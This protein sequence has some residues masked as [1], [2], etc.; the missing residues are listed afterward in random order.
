LRQIVRDTSAY[1]L[2]G[3][4][5]TLNQPDGKFHKI[6]VRVK[7]PGV[8]VRARPGYLALNAEEAERATAPRRPG[9]PAAVTQALATLATTT[10]RSPI[11]SW[12][13]MSPGENGKTKISFVWNPTPP[14]PGVRAE[15]PARVTLIAGGANSDLY[16]RGK[17]LPPGRTVFEVPPGPI[18]LEIAV[19]D[20]E[21]EVLDRETRKVLVPSMGLGLTLSTP[22]VFRGRTLPEWQKLAADPAALPVIE[23]EFRRTDRLLLRVGAQSSGGTPIISARMLNR[24]GGEM[25]ALP[26]TPAG[27]G[28]L[29]NIDVPLAALPTGDFLLEVTAK[30]GAEQ[31]STLVAFRVTP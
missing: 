4:T 28:G 11:R 29:S 17:S 9:P 14:A 26:A 27:F 25:S 16:Y 10:R 13:G 7:R 20:A 15:T 19:E 2:L 21:A 3:Y 30:D 5:S 6:N 8:Q 31:A 22:E 1:Y 23:R 24:E 12:I 18:E